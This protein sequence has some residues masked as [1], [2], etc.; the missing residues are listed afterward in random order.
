[1]VNNG[2]HID[3]DNGNLG[4]SQHSGAIKIFPSGH[5]FSKPT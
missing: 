2:Y 5:P 3:H 4:V 1:M